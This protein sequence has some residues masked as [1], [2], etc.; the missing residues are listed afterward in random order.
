MKRYIGLLT[1]I[2]IILFSL[3][4]CA[5]KETSKAP[6]LL[7][8]IAEQNIEGPQ[9]CWWASEVDLSETEKVLASK[10]IENGFQ[11]LEPSYVINKVI[12]THKAF[13]RVDL[14]DEETIKLGDISGADY[15]LLGTALVSAGGVV[16]G[17]TLLRSCSAN[18]NVKIIRVKDGQIISQLASSAGSVHTDMIAGGKEALNKAANDLANK[19]LYTIIDIKSGGQK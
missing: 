1:I 11:I 18:I 2:S 13:R 5:K 17:S 14:K 7:L 16:P 6:K 8:L 3:L 19:I 15:V 9:T 10:L 4:G 12:K